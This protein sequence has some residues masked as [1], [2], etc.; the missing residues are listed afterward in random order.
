MTVLA[1]GAS[2]IVGAIYLT[3]GIL[4]V[5]DLTR[6]RSLF[7]LGFAGAAFTCG[8]HHLAHGL[9]QLSGEG[10][11]GVEAVSVV[12]GLPFASAFLALRVL[13]AGGRPADLVLPGRTGPL[14]L[15]AVVLAGLSGAVAA[16]AI[17]SADGVDL[18]RLVPGV[19]QSVAYLGVAWYLLQTQW[20]RRDSQGEWSVSGLSLVGIFTTCAVSHL[21]YGVAPV[22]DDWHSAAINWAGMPASMFFCAVAFH[23]HRTARVRWARQPAMHRV[24]AG[25]A[26]P[27]HPESGRASWDPT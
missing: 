21:V 2:V 26:P 18:G 19:V 1:G 9:H 6:Y 25:V 3:L 7:G 23:L 16:I 24:L 15:V 13:Q 14:V 17:G 4:T 8:P 22:A 27:W 5:A 20:L 10:F 11:S 12:Y